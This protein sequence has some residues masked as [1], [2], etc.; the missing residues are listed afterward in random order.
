M[1]LPVCCVD[2]PI[3][4]GQNKMDSQRNNYWFSEALDQDFSGMTTASIKFVLRMMDGCLILNRLG[5]RGVQL[6]QSEGNIA[7]VIVKM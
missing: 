1:S 6:C 7:V 5:R 2:V 3:T 4:V